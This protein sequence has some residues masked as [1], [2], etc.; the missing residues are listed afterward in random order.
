MRIHISSLSDKASA[1]KMTNKNAE[2]Y[3]AR[4]F[5]KFDSVC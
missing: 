2:L 5:V 1:T 4:R 3:K